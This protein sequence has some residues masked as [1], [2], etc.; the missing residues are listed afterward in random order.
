MGRGQYAPEPL[1]CCAAAAEEGALLLLTD[2]RLL[3]ASVH[4]SRLLWHTPMREV[5]RVAGAGG[6]ARLGAGP[7]HRSSLPRR[8]A[9]CAA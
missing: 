3:C 4:G 8:L 9:R 7:S 1:M 5:R 6:R 2:L